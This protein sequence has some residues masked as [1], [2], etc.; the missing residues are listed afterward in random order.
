[1]KKH[2]ERLEQLANGKG[3]SKTALA[4]AVGVS[5]QAITNDFN[6]LKISRKGIKKYVGVLLESEDEFYATPVLIVE[7]SVSVNVVPLNDFL[8]LQRRYMELSDRYL[9]L[10][11][12]FFPNAAQREP[13]PFRAMVSA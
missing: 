1:M 13:E 6:A 5:V 8:E 11:E 3:Y 7:S 12:R 10:T 4:N 9:K 2:G